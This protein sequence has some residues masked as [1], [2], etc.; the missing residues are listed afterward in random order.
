MAEPVN[1]IATIRLKAAA[2]VI[3]LEVLVVVGLK[4]VLTI[5]FRKD[6]SRAVEV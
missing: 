6:E 3:S 5:L 4:S 2:I 1:K